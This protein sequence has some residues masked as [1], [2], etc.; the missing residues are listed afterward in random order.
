[1]A[2]GLAE[3]ARILNDASLIADMPMNGVSK[4][5][6]LMFQVDQLAGEEK[7]RWSPS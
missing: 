3:Q 7:A 1:M 5:T 6:E 4:S 2:E